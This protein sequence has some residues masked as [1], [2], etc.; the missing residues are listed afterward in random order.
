MK[1]ATLGVVVMALVLASCGGGGSD[2]APSR[3]APT[4]AAVTGTAS[5]DD[6]DE[7]VALDDIE[8]EIRRVID[9]YAKAFSEED[10]STSYDL[11]PPSVRETC[12]RGRAMTNVA[13]AVEFAKAF[14]GEDA[15]EALKEDSADG[16]E[17]Q[18]IEI[19]G[20]RAVVFS[21]EVPDGTELVREEGR[22][23]VAGEVGEEGPC[24]ETVSE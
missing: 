3:G 1:L 17:I 19:T 7:E 6:G 11:L 24:E 8:S 18:S 10:W 2:S 20:D 15:W 22:W 4:Q 21:L 23:W 9:E 14:I 13:V 16:Y 5:S 12:L